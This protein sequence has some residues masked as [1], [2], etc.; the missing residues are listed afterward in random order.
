[1]I[2]WLAGPWAKLKAG[3]AFAGVAIA[4]IGIAFLRGRSAGIKHIEA[5]QNARR[6]DALKQRKDVDH[7]VQNLGSND[8]DSQFQRWLRDD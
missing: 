2:G 6:I 4:A 7:E 1:M 5:E 3:L 8:F